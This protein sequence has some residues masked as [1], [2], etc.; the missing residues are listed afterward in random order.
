MKRSNF[1]NP[2]ASKMT[3]HIAW[4]AFCPALVKGGMLEETHLLA[5]DAVEE[6][7]ACIVPLYQ[8]SE[9]LQGTVQLPR[10]VVGV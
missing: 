2:Y 4:G 1:N 3:T 5:D 6:V 7:G 8:A 10:P 9:P